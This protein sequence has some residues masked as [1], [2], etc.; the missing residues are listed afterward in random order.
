VLLLSEAE[1]ELKHEHRISE[2]LRERMRLIDW[3]EAAD[4][5]LDGERVPFVCAD[6]EL[7][8]VAVARGLVTL[9]RWTSD[10]LV[11][12]RLLLLESQCVEG[13]AVPRCVLET[14]VSRRHRV[15]GGVLRALASLDAPQRAQLRDLF[16]R[17][18]LPQLAALCVVRGASSLGLVPNVYVDSVAD[19]VAGTLGVAPADAALAFAAEGCALTPLPGNESLATAAHETA[20]LLSLRRLHCLP[21]AALLGASTG[22]R[23]RAARRVLRADYG[24]WLKASGVKSSSISDHSEL[25]AA[26]SRELTAVIRPLTYALYAMLAFGVDAAPPSTRSVGNSMCCCWGRKKI[27]LLIVNDSNRFCYV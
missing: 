5:A 15:D 12:Y 3:Q 18:L 11:G 21:G 19:E 17:P 26:L 27:P 25:L 7:C 24:V 20:L 6:R 9:E 8:D 1:H 23:L 14:T 22:V 16:F 2:A 13:E 10:A 4:A